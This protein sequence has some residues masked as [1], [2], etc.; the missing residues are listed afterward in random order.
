MSFCAGSLTGYYYDKKLVYITGVYAA[1]LGFSEQKLYLKDT[2]PY[3]LSYR[4]YFAEWGK[5]YLKYPNKELDLDEKKMTYSDT[6]FHVTFTNP[7]KIVK[8]SKNKYV[9][10]KMDKDLLKYLTGCVKTMFAELES[11]KTSH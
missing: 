4:Q 10:N 5:Y 11:E 8:T 1:E 7:I 9:D 6:I 3:K 2:I